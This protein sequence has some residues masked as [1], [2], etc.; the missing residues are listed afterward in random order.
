MALAVP[1]P[2]RGSNCIVPSPTMSAMQRRKGDH[3]ANVF[4]ATPKDA[5]VRLDKTGALYVATASYGS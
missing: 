5:Q 2:M 1:P 3:H 4:H